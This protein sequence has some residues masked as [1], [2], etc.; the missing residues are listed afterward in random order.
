M[1]MSVIARVKL[2]RPKPLMMRFAGH[3]GISLGDHGI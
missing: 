2:T 1:A 3:I